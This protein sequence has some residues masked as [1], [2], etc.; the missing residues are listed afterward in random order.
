MAVV[1]IKYL[2]RIGSLVRW[3]NV[4]CS[5]VG[6]RCEIKVPSFFIAIKMA[7]DLGIVV[8]IVGVLPGC[9]DEIDV[10]MFCNICGPLGE[11]P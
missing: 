7:T 8:V 2:V 5:S 9:L 1:S 3:I 6:G 10:Q 11:C 4:D